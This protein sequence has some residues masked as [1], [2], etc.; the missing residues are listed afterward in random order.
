MADTAIAGDQTTDDYPG[1]G[2][3]SYC[4]ALLFVAYI[5]SFI[6]RQILALLVGPIREDFG[7]TD[8]QYSLLQG[9]AFALLY[10]FAGLPI[11][12][13]ADRHSRKFI[14]FVSVTFWSLATV[15]C[16][17]TKNFGQPSRTPCKAR[18]MLTEAKASSHHK[19]L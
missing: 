12:R 15:A 13:L 16:G 1:I 9:A 14:V 5:F 2:S 4:L 18:Q 3:A 7:I 19:G 10:T 6:D 17:L 11:G 8:F